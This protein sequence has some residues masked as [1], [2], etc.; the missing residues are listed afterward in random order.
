MSL[1][2]A[3]VFLIVGLFIDAI[4]A[5]IIMGSIM[6]PLAQA[7]GIHPIHFS[8]VGVVAL[9]FGLVTPPY[10]MCLLIAA[11]IGEMTIHHV[12]KDVFIFLIPMLGILMALCFFPDIVLFLPRLIS[13]QFM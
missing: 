10:G 3:A 2:I 7:V 12:L 5:I 8:I 4:P 6:Y 1:I 11:R 13:P 9:A